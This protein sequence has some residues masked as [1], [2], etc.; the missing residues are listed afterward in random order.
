[1]DECENNEGDKQAPAKK[2]KKSQQCHKQP[3][4]SAEIEAAQLQ[5]AQFFKTLENNVSAGYKLSAVTINDDDI[6]CAENTQK[7]QTWNA[8]VQY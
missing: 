1:M 2:K 5:A 6:T 3:K 4:R 8:N 7:E